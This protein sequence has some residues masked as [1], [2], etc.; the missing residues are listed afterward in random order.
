MNKV[1]IRIRIRKD[2]Y[3]ATIVKDNT[4]GYIDKQYLNKR[5]I[6]EIKEYGFAYMHIYKEFIV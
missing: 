3:Y 1:R 4:E 2:M 6:K 5:V